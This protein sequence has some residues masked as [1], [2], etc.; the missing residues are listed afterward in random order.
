MSLEKVEDSFQFEAEAH[1][2]AGTEVEE[3]HIFEVKKDD[4]FSLRRVID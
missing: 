4:N 1:R 3:V 2:L